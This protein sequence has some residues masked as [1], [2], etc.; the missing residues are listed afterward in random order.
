M[1]YK[2]AQFFSFSGVHPYLHKGDTAIMA[3]SLHINVSSL[4]SNMAEH[5]THSP[6]YLLEKQDLRLFTN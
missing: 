1:G 4:N 6:L 2:K 5:M 3:L